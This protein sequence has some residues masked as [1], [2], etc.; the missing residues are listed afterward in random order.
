MSSR[1]LGPAGE[2]RYTDDFMRKVAL[3]DFPDGHGESEL[4]VTL[5]GEN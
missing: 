3:D 5:T 2:Q 1:Y 4:V